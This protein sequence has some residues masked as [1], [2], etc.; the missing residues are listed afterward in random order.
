MKIG[1]PMDKA[2]GVS[3]TRSEGAA[4]TS[5]SGKASGATGVG[6]SAKVT[7]SSAA[8]GLMDNS[9]G[10]FDAGKVASVKQAI[11]SGSYKVNHEAIAD[12]LI[13]NAKE[14]LAH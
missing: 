10:S 8:A 1:N 9:D 7:L 11:D 2:L 13:S 4:S 6:E 14:L 12:K 3:G 5:T